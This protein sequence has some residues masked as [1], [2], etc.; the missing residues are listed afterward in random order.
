MRHAPR[1]RAVPQ[2]GVGASVVSRSILTRGLRLASCQAPAA[3][4]Q[5]HCL[6]DVLRLGPAVWTGSAYACCRGGILRRPLWASFVVAACKVGGT[7]AAPSRAGA[8]PGRSGCGLVAV[9]GLSWTVG[10][11]IV[12]GCSAQG[13][14]CGDA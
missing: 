7:V 6:G 1:V 11:R 13:V 9:M 4:C 3:G 8:Q 12:Q 14:C 5:K 2:P 10:D